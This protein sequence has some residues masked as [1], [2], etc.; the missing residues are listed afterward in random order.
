MDL[1]YVYDDKI[2]CDRDGNYYTGSAFSQAIFDRY[3]AQFDTLT[4]LMR[5][6]PVSPDDVQTLA[7]MNRLT[8]ARIRV[9]FY[10]DRRE[11]LRAFLSLQRRREIRQIITRSITPERA[12]I[13]RVPSES[14]TIAA[15]FCRRIGKPFLAEAV[16]CPWDSL[17][18]HSLRGKVLAPDAWLR[19]RW[20]MRHAPY[21]VYV[22]N[23]FLQRRYP[24][25]GISAAVSDV[26]LAPAD[27]A[28]LA[29]RLEKIRTHSGKLVLGTAAA[30]NVAFKGQRYVI[31]ALA[32]L[33]AAG[34]T[35]VEY[36]LAGGGDPTALR[37][38]A[39]RLT[40]SGIFDH[41][42]FLI[43][44]P[45]RVLERKAR[46]AVFPLQGFRRTGGRLRG[47]DLLR[48]EPGLGG[49]LRE[50]RLVAERLLKAGARRADALRALLH[51]AADLDRAVIAQKAPDLPCDLRHSVRRKACTELFIKALHGLEK[52]DAA[53]LVQVVGLD[54]AA[55]KAPRHAPDEAGVFLDHLLRRL[56]VTRLHTPQQRTHLFGDH[57]RRRMRRH[58]VTVVPRPGTDL[59]RSVS[60]KLS[61]IVKPMPLRSSPP[62]V[63]IGVRAC[64]TSA[65]P[66]P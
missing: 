32:R 13:I 50:R 25:R 56:F 16:G 38:L 35:D 37:E 20:C 11:S 33:K 59:T 51:A 41:A 52:A 43:V 58:M 62:V 29:R 26:E 54:A 66:T 7:R 17:T 27:A 47:R 65:M 34:R 64:A 23:A 2:A 44:V 61:M 10:P 31:E 3:L 4:L 45:E 55:E 5:R 12:V 60:M 19:M 28:V 53:E 46:L 8:D 36:R 30:V 9:V 14:G 48:L 40:Q 49:E 42:L 63:Y 39:Q 15:R 1:L 22:T 18:H 24:T 57:A 6:A 21:A